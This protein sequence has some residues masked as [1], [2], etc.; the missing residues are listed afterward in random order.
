MPSTAN[1]DKNQ[2]DSNRPS[3]N[4][5]TSSR[6]N[7]RNDTKRNGGAAILEDNQDINDALEGRKF[8]EKHSLLCPPGEPPTHDS[9]STCLHQISAMA[10]VPKPVLNAIRAVAFLLEEM[11]ETRINETVKEAFDSQITEFTSDMKLLI[12]DAKEK[13]DTHLK[14]SEE[15]IN[16]ML[17]DAAQT[18]QAQPT[19]YATAL[20][21]PPP[22]AN[23]K[24][25]AREG[26]K[27]RQFL[28]EGI[29][30]TKFS[31]LDTFQLKSELNK[32]L[33]EM[34]SD[35]GKIRSANNLRNSAVLIELDSDEA[36][37]W[38]QKAENRSNFCCKIGPNVASRTRIHNLIA[39]N[40]PLT[41][42]P[43]EIGHQQEICE[44]NNMEKETITTMRWAKPINRRSPNQRTA[45]LIIT[46][47]NADTANRAITDGLY[48]CNR[49]CHVE[50][51]K[52]EPTRCLKCQGWN[53]Y[54]RDCLE[55][56]DKCGN[57]ARNH[58]TGSCP[59]PHATRCVSCKTDDHASWSRECPTFTKKCNEFDSR[60]PENALQYI[61]TADPWTWTTSEKEK[62]APQ[63]AQAPAVKPSKNGERT[64]PSKKTHH[65][66]R[67]HDTYIPSS[68]AYTPNCDTYIPNYDAQR[69]AGPSIFTNNWGN[70]IPSDL[71]NFEPFTQ[72]TIDNMN[73]EV[74]NRTTNPS[75]T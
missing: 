24:I 53:H 47:S 75:H 41:I 27:A 14:S 26:I 58:R 49:R 38:F 5:T 60:N 63:T 50:K 13:I 22:H 35:K 4:P 31:H 16:Q 52:R 74:T 2:S 17:S 11:E 45:H 15:R 10:S 59:T 34:G 65:D 57:C 64:Q 30:D 48:I 43:E 1:K 21:N 3:P 56:E 28:L 18:K 46:F 72:Q 39:F 42:S 66:Q 55:K 37:A 12:E 69:K 9:L 25:A 23:P 67:K 62:Q 19:T 33:T 54:A 44:A 20:I 32:I 29:K 36:T 61:P 73:D 7:T 70:H 8:L 6:P 40:V 71:L 68:N 51:V